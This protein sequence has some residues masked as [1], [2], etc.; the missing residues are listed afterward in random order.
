MLPGK[1][2]QYPDAFL[3]VTTGS[4]VATGHPGGIWW[5]ETRDTYKHPAVHMTGPIAENDPDKVSIVPSCETLMEGEQKTQ[6]QAP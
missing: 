2:E 1:I 3:V 5:L 4:G 6:N